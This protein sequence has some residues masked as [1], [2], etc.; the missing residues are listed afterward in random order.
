MNLR[1]IVW[2]F[3]SGDFI[4][5]VN[6]N[7]VPNMESNTAQRA[8]QAKLINSGIIALQ[9][10]LYEATVDRAPGVIEEVLKAGL[11][12]MTVAECMN[13]QPYSDSSIV[14][15]KSMSVIGSYNG[16][17]GSRNSATTN[18]RSLIPIMLLGLTI[19]I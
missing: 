16:T 9:H 14:L 11:N 8:N 15:P 5:G 4:L 3:D 17:T 18:P 1:P 12:P 7:A 13:I 10:D 19:L 2:N 6:K